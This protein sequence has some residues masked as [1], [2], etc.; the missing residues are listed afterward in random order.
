MQRLCFY[1]VYYFVI[2][3]YCFNCLLFDLKVEDYPC[4]VDQNLSY[5]DKRVLCFHLCSY[6]FVD[7]VPPFESFDFIDRGS[8]TA[9]SSD[10]F[11]FLV[12]FISNMP[13]QSRFSFV[14]FMLVF[15]K[16]SMPSCDCSEM[17]C[18]YYLSFGSFVSI[19]WVSYYYFLFFCFEHVLMQKHCLSF[20]DFSRDSYSILVYNL[21]WYYLSHAIVVFIFIGCVPSSTYTTVVW[22][23]SCFEF[24]VSSASLVNYIMNL[25][26]YSNSKFL[27]YFDSRSNFVFHFELNCCLFEADSITFNQFVRYFLNQTD[28][29]SCPC[30]L[31]KKIL[32][33]IHYYFAIFVR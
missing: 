30:C 3:K 9:N 29:S 31:A 13:D 24:M 27:Y 18:S 28:L 20:V 4:D 32:C 10:C 15:V 23:P 17:S 8:T 25:Y 26:L 2:G 19:H 14:D 1:L 12:S 21:G 33:T 11:S 6:S 16:D 22:F 7:F 5:L